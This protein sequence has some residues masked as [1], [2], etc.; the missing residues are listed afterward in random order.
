MRKTIRIYSSELK[1]IVAELN[2]YPSLETGGQLLGLRTHGQAHTIFLATGPEPNGVHEPAYFLQDPLVHQAVEAFAWSEFG[3]QNIGFWHS[4]HQLP[5][6]ELSSGDIRRSMHYATAHNRPNI[7]DI[8]G[9][10]EGDRT[11]IRG[12]VYSDARKGHM[13]PTQI[14]I[15]TGTSPFRAMLSKKKISMEL[16]Q[17]FSKVPRR[18]IPKPTLHFSAPKPLWEAISE[19]GSSE[20]LQFDSGMAA[21]EHFMGHSVPSDLHEHT[22]LEMLSEQNFKLHIRLASTQMAL[23]FEWSNQLQLRQILSQCGNTVTTH[24][25]LGS[26][27][28]DFQR[29]LMC[30]FPLHPQS[31]EQK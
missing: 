8:L 26:A 27:H 5:F 21:I 12:Y 6:H 13:W 1:L 18:K 15:M 2:R 22:E 31:S 24:P 11:H 4:H 25:C 28:Q 7:V 14:E 23:H 29:A 20:A 3:L 16:A 19:T 9:W 17:S 30:L 10:L